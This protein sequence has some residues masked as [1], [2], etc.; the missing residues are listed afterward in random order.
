MEEN[1]NFSNELTLFDLFRILFKRWLVLLISLIVGAGAGVL[2]AFIK[3]ASPDYYGTTV[4]FYV[5]PVKEDIKSKLPVYGSYGNNITETMVVLLESEYFAEKIISG[6]S[7][8]P[9]KEIEGKINPAYVELLREIQEYTSFSNKDESLSAET[10]QPNNIFYATIKVKADADFA[11]V[12]L[13]RLQDEAVDFIEENMPVPSGYESTKC[14]PISVI[15]DIEKIVDNNTSNDL[16]KFSVLG[17][18]CAFV[19][20]CIVVVVIDRYKNRN[21]N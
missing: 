18:G 19:L 5:N 10:N 16:L 17:G 20:A 9:E 11:K 1:T 15:N 2:A 13:M 14:I 6:V 12:L 7:G 21:S 3:N 8:V 4:M